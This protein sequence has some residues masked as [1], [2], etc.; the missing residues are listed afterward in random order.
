VRRSSVIRHPCTPL[1]RGD[2]VN[3]AS[4]RLWWPCEL[5]HDLTIVDEVDPCRCR[6]WHPGGS[7]GELVF[8]NQS[9]ESI[10]PEQSVAVWTR[11]GW[12]DVDVL[13]RCS[14]VERAVGT[15]RVVV[16]EGLGEHGVKMAAIENEEMS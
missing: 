14:L 7:G 13:E 8:V 12:A 5:E 16:V 3:V 6:E 10:T 11:N 4:L 2:F 15:V 1:E 9:G